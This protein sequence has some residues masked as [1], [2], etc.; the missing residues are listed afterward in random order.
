MSYRFLKPI[1]Y[2]LHRSESVGRNVRSPDR[3]A[4]Q[5]FTRRPPAMCGTPKL[6]RETDHRS[7][8]AWRHSRRRL[9]LRYF[10]AAAVSAVDD[11]DDDGHVDV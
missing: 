10:P 6:T 9:Q 2:R 7:N 3:V 11:D 5:S 8:Y 4:D 1:H